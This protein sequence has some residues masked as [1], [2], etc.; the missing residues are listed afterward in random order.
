MEPKDF[1]TKYTPTW[2]P[3]C[4]GW[5]IFQ[6]LKT[7]LAT[8][9]L[10]PHQTVIVY[11]IGCSGN[12]ND[13]V[14][15]YAFHSLHG[16]AV[17]TASGIKMA[18]HQLTVICIVGDGDCYGEGGNHLLHAA[19]GNHDIKVFVHD[20]RI[21][22]LTTGQTSPTSPRGFLSKSTPKGAI[23]V[24]LNPLSLAISQGGTF[25]AQGY[26]GNPGQLASL[27]TK[28]IKHKGFALLNILQPCVTF[29]KFNTFEFYKE[30]IYQ[31]DESW[32]SQDKLSVLKKVSA[33]SEKIPT[34]V[35]YQEKRPAYH[36]HLPQIKTKSLVD[37]TL[38]INVDSLF[39]EF[40]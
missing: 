32:N 5:G 30:R 9:G 6:S 20:N 7:A 12:M 33:P 31:V 10:K 15:T 22:G 18:N 19:R 28:A 13:F 36:Q 38:K 14:K 4:G 37:Q 16:R 39:G 11:G 27:M 17:P 8:L 29:N 25:V 21:Y 24:P 26:A 2:C 35:I 1:E 40:V 34:G 3:G 23:E